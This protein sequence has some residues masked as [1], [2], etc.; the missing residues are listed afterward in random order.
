[1]GTKEEFSDRTPARSTLDSL[2]EGIQILDRDFRYV[3]VNDAAA[4]HGRTTVS[5][6]VGMRMEEC[7]PGIE[8]TELFGLLRSCMSARTPHVFE[9]RFTYP[10]GTTGDFEL[11]IEPVPE[12][13]CVM[14][15]DVSGRRRAEAKAADADRRLALSERME[16]IGRLSAGIAHDFNTYL[17]I[18]MGYG[19]LALARS[20]GPTAADIQA[21]L[22][23]ARHSAD[24]TRQLLAFGRR[25][26]MTPELVDP[27][28]LVKG[29]EEMMRRVLGGSVTLVVTT[30]PVG[31]IRVDPSQFERVLLNLV[32]NARDAMP[33]GGTVTIDLSEAEGPAGLPGRT[34]VLAV[35]DTGVGMDEETR[36]RAFEPFFTTKDHAHGTGLGLASVY[37]IVRQHGG[38]IVVTSAKG[39][40]ST[41]AVHVPVSPDTLAP[42]APKPEPRPAPS[43]RDDRILVAEDNATLRKVIGITLTSGGFRPV[44]AASGEEALAH[45]KGPDPIALL[46]TDVMLPGMRGPELLSKARELRPELRVLCTS[47]YSLDV[48]DDTGVLG[49]DVAFIEKPYLPSALLAKIRELLEDDRAVTT[50]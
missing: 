16:A 24:L 14:S 39:A 38:D 25:Q 29:F 30:R 5:A 46:V 17:A 42:P 50:P 45:C 1:M 31:A 47:G 22:G 21:I 15:I 34:V 3:Y 41:F 44:L 13:V 43:K 48:L 37:G 20:G 32:L 12:G 27:V 7:Y 4:R 8:G 18:V 33:E 28:A 10:D 19:E 36:R 23:A 49:R 6:L 26:W 11:R 2:L 9:N 35:T 40:G